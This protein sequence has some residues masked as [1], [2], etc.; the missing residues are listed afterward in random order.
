MNIVY[1]SSEAAPFIKTGGLADVAGSLPKAIR[2]KG[3][4]ISLVLP[5][6][7]Q[8][9]DKYRE[10]MVKVKHFYVDLQWRHVYAGILKYEDDELD[11]YFIDNEY[12]FKRDG[13][14]GY[15]DDGERFTF[16]NKA[17]CQML[18]ELD[19]KPDIVHANDWHTGLI[20]LYIKDFAK[21]DPY[22]KDIKSVFTIHNLKY[23]GVFD[24][25]VLSI[26]GLSFEYFTTDGVEFFDK[27]NFL[28]AGIVY[29]DALTTVSK[30]Y[31][32]EIR[33]D[34]YG[35]NLQG[36]IRKH[37]HKLVGI[38]N[39]ID[40]D[41]YNPET[42]KNIPFNYNINNLENKKKNKL[43]LQKLYNLP[44]DENIP[45][46]SIVSR[47]VSSKGFDLIRYILEEILK[48]DVQFVVLGT[49]E[50]EYEDMFKMYAWKYEKK[51]S[52]HI[53]FNQRESH[54]VYAGSDIFLMPSLFEPCGISQLIAMRYGTIPVVRETGGLKDT[55]IPYNK[56]T[57]EGTGFSFANY[58]AHELLFS[59]KEAIS[60]YK[61][62]ENWNN[63]VVQAMTAKHDWENSSIEYI[64]LF[65]SLLKK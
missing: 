38:V 62:K 37:E 40:Y 19:L 42:D 2:K 58:N 51:L 39:G 34:F 13:I 9:D 32:E 53:Y 22:Y 8:I 48:E 65:E 24:K 56:Y 60:L 41:I 5:L 26:A 21:G 23:Q 35:E 29:S 52:A 27:I 45:L 36:I 12:Y 17:V 47:L 49:G 33:Y 1:V 14:Y 28:K 4:K 54:L 15:F 3:Q 7:S 55:V 10:K 11:V 44:Q 64:K 50:R 18:K 57:G 25:E 16:F 63:L 30:T 6:Y 20:P 59:V 43:E 31:A 46:I 61:D